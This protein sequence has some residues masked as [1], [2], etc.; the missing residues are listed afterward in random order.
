MFTANISRSDNFPEGEIDAEA[1]NGMRRVEAF[2]FAEVA[3]LAD[4]A[5]SKAVD[6]KIM[7]VRL[8]PS[9]H[10]KPSPPRP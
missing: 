1:K 4:A 6:R 10:L 8:P 3:E 7:R 5:A 2:L 9:A